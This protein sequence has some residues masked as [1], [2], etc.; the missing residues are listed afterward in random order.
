MCFQFGNW[1]WAGRFPGRERSWNV[2]IL[3]VFPQ[4]VYSSS[5]LVLS[6]SAFFWE[7][8]GEI[9]LGVVNKKAQ[10]KQKTPKTPNQKPK[11]HITMKR[12][13]I[14]CPGTTHSTF[15]L[16]SRRNLLPP[17]LQHQIALA[18][19]QGGM[20]TTGLCPFSW[21]ALSRAQASS[22][23]PRQKGGNQPQAQAEKKTTDRQKKKRL[24]GQ[25]AV[26]HRNLPF[27]SWSLT[28]DV[29]FLL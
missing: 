5:S 14:A 2:S 19:P 26:L 28:P 13:S 15:C 6:L 22:L 23:F 4:T 21:G 27:H 11:Q 17:E 29:M 1:E 18:G 9:F 10:T 20:G 25:G 7:M 12:N 8:H 16:N 24:T 3:S